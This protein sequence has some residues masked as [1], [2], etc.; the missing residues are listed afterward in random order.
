MTRK[1]ID[2][3]TRLG[4]SNN[5]ITEL[6]NE[7]CAA[8][9]AKF[10]LPIVSHP[11]VFA[12]MPDKIDYRVPEADDTITEKVYPTLKGFQVFVLFDNQFVPETDEIIAGAFES[13]KWYPD[14]GRLV[15]WQG[16][17]YTAPVE[18]SEHITIIPYKKKLTV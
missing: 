10:N 12:S 16:F 4:F 5:F 15:K 9:C 2:I 8:G 18:E 1:D 6:T 14:E 11:P 17:H 3:L 7:F 13:Y